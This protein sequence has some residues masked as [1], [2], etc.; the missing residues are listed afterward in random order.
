[1]YALGNVS[2]NGE[3]IAAGVPVHVMTSSRE[4]ARLELHVGDPEFPLP[5]VPDGYLRVVWPDYEGGYDEASDYAQYAWGSGV[6]I[7]LLGFALAAAR[8]T[9]RGERSG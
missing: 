8:R 9:H 6:L 2:A 4:G 3:L 5:A 7:V 1:M